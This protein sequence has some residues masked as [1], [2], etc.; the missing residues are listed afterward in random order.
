[1]LNLGN[2]EPSLVPE[3]ILPLCCDPV[4]DSILAIMQTVAADAGRGG[5]AARWRAFMEH[6]LRRVNTEDPV[7]V[8]A[9]SSSGLERKRSEGFLSH[10]LGPVPRRAGASWRA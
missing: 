10:L 1:M 2:V 9:R 3:G 5:G 6:A 7:G 8:R 4:R